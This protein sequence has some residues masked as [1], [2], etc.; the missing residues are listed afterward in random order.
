MGLLNHKRRLVYS[1]ISGVVLAA[2]AGGSL[3]LLNKHNAE[4]NLIV[5]D[6]ALTIVQQKDGNTVTIQM[7]MSKEQIDNL[8]G[9]PEA[10]L[11]PEGSD[12]Y[13]YDDVTVGYMDD[14]LALFSFGE[15]SSLS[16]GI[17]LETSPNE[18]V[19][20][21]GEASIPN[22][23]AYGYHWDSKTDSLDLVQGEE[24]MKQLE[25]QPDFYQLQFGS[26]ALGSLSS[27]QIS[28]SDYTQALEKHVTQMNE[29]VILDEPALPITLADLSMIKVDG[30][31][32]SAISLGMTR[33]EAEA[34]VGEPIS[35]SR[36][37]GVGYDGILVAYRNDKVVALTIRLSEESKTLYKTV[38]GAGLLNSRKVIEGLYGLATSYQSPYLTYLISSGDTVGSLHLLTE[39][40][41]NEST[42]KP[43]YYLSM[44][45]NTND[46][47]LVEFLSIS[48]LQFAMTGK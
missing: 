48:D 43:S 16:N 8:L 28:R 42:N 27:I 15:N 29:A 20:K 32:Q 37:G 35:D 46:D 14:H 39:A 3:I 34:I 11:S 30:G 7:G 4:D 21:L 45:L 18:A 44:L 23:M 12:Y 5:S 40:E 19:E 2:A 47:E 13:M 6:K 33:K 9:E 10:Y 41:M 1:V 36:I 26:N 25:G 31:A 38:R 17:S 24:L 22:S